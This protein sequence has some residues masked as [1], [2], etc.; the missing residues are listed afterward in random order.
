[1]LYRKARTAAISRKGE[2]KSAHQPAIKKNAMPATASS[3]APTM[4]ANS[5]STE[6]I[7]PIKMTSKP[8]KKC[9]GLLVIPA[10]LPRTCKEEYKRLTTKART[11]PTRP[12][13]SASVRKVN[14]ATDLL[15]L[16]PGNFPAPFVPFFRSDA[17]ALESI[18][19]KHKAIHHPKD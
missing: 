5:A 6:P 13:I 19:Q 14:C 11:T 12:T 1:M 17:L 8:K 18:K 15:L 4:G 7:S 9:D 10:T 3:T 2:A 16:R